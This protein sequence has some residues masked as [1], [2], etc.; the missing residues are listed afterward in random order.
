MEYVCVAMAYDENGLPKRDVG[1]YYADIGMV[2][3]K[4]MQ[5]EERDAK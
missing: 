1:T 3:T 5:K 2:W 4:E